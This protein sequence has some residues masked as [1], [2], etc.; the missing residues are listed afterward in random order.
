MAYS[1]PLMTWAV[2]VTGPPSRVM[3]ASG[4]IAARAG[5][6]ACKPLEPGPGAMLKLRLLPIQS[7]EPNEEPLRPSSQVNIWRPVTTGTPRASA[8][9][10][11]A[12][13]T[14]E[15][16]ASVCALTVKLP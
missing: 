4:P 14:S 8:A 3:L 7:T 6:S 15:L 16:T 9:V 11:T 2:Y 10:T 13:A 12:S 1:M 5:T